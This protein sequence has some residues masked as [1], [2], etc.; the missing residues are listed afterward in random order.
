MTNIP[1]PSTIPLRRLMRGKRR[2]HSSA[3]ISTLANSRFAIHDSGVGV[4]RLDGKVAIVTG[5]ASGIGKGIV[6]RFVAEG[7]RVV[8]G[9]PDSD[10]T[11]ALIGELGH[12]YVDGAAIDVRDEAAVDRLVAQAVRR[13]GRLDV[14]VNN[15]GVGGFSPIQ[16]YQQADWDR[17]IGITLTGAFLCVKHEAKRLIAQ[18]NG[19]SI[20]NIA[21]LN[22][23]QPTEGFAAYC[24]AKAGVAMLTKVAAL[25]LGRHK[26]RVNAIGPGLIHTPATAGMTGVPGVEEAFIHEAPM[27]RPGEPEDVAGLALYLASDESSLMSGQTLYIDGGASLNKYPELFRLFGVA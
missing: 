24:S 6:Q 20:V 9:D 25:E 18:G 21:S 5:G 19:G 7:A 27:G 17:V 16:E 10:G 22:A 12:N 3:R 14:A 23:V 11:G 15:A 8:I 2:S 1:N 13:F 4:A 26:I